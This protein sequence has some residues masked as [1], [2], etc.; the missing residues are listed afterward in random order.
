MAATQILSS[1]LDAKLNTNIRAKRWQAFMKSLNVLKQ[2][3]LHCYASISTNISIKNNRNIGREIKT[4]NMFESIMGNSL[5]M[6]KFSSG[7]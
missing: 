3:I 6:Q 4:G 1:I 7:F 5:S 2:N